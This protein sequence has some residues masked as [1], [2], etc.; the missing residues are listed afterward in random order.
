MD[1]GRLRFRA[2]FTQVGKSAMPPQSGATPR[3]R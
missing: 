3:G 2:K 1:S